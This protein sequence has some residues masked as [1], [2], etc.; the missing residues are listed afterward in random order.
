MKPDDALMQSAREATAKYRAGREDQ[1]RRIYFDAISRGHKPDEARTIACCAALMGA[2][3]QFTIDGQRLDVRVA[4]MNNHW[5]S[6]A[7]IQG[8]TSHGKPN[9]VS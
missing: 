4:A 1:L 5:F 2:P 3:Y 9:R 8:G 6:D 7:A